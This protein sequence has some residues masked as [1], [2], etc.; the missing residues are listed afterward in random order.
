MA[1]TP[2]PSQAERVA[3]NA[4]LRAGGGCIFA[5][6]SNAD[7]S[8]AAIRHQISMHRNITRLRVTRSSRASSRASDGFTTIVLVSSSPARSFT[9]LTRIR[10]I[11]RCP[12]RP[13]RCLQTGKLCFTNRGR[14]F[15]V[16]VCYWRPIAEVVGFKGERHKPWY[17]SLTPL[18]R[19]R[20]PRFN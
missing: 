5:D 18:D 11:N 9:L 19:R 12:D 6:V 16:D 3:S 4:R 17:S 20:F 15:G 10:W 8:A 13:K 1:S 14:L 2:Q 7:T